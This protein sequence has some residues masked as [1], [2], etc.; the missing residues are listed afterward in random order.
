M[1]KITF[2]D[3]SRSFAVLAVWTAFTVPA[4]AGAIL[5]NTPV[6]QASAG[7]TYNYTTGSTD[8]A[9]YGAGNGQFDHASSQVPSLFSPIAAVSGT[10]G[11]GTDAKSLVTTTNGVNSSSGLP[12]N[13]TASPNFTFNSNNIV[14]SGTTFTFSMSA[15]TS[16]TVTAYLVSYDANTTFTVSDAAGTL[17]TD[18]SFALP[19]PDGTGGGGHGYGYFNFN[20]ASSLADTITFTDTVASTAGGFANVGFQGV[21]AAVIPEPG[22]AGVFLAGLALVVGRRRR[23]D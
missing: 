19:S 20:F 22:V 5:L 18:T 6:V 16:A 21:T 2:S 13:A 7:T 17:F 1:L 12:E 11:K 23:R 8:F 4:H 15:H 3:G 14:G 9:F 10:L